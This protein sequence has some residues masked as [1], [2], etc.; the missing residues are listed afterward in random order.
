MGPVKDGALKRLVSGVLALL[1]LSY[2]GYQVYRSK[3][4][5]VRTETAE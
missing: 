2:V 3:H 1:L 5:E 4:T